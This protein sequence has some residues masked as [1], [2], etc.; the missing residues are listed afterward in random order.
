MSTILVVVLAVT[1]LWFTIATR[2]VQFRLIGDMMRLLVASDA[3]AMREK[4]RKHISSF[5]AFSVSIASRVGTGNLAGVATAIVIGGPGAIFWMWVMAIIGS[6]N[7][8]VESTLAQ[9]FKIKAKDSY[10]GGPAYYIKKGL[11][12]KFFAYVFAVS[13]IAC[14]GFANNMV[15]SNTISLAFA[16]AFGTNQ[17]VL[18]VIM[19]IVA[20][21]IFFG[22]IQRVAKVS[23]V[24]VPIMALAYVFVTLVVIVLQ[25][26]RIPHV[27]ALIV[28]NAFGIEQAVGGGVGTAILFGFKR[29]LFSNEAGEGSAPNAAATAS[30]SHPVNQGLIQALGV[31]TDTLIICT[32]TAFLIL[33][34][35]VFDNGHSGIELTQ[36]AMASVIGSAGY[37]FVAVAIFLFA[38]T[39]VIGNYYYGECN[40]YFMTRSKVA[41]TIYRL[42]VGAMVLAG[43]V[44]TLNLVWSCVDFFM[45]IM[46]TVNLVSILLLCKYALRCLHHYQEQKKMG[47]K[48]KY[49]S[50]VIPEIESETEAWK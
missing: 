30:T 18:G 25:Y 1:A 40:L 23:M 42:L 6:A 10:V 7:A 44:S 33:C 22:G 38:F 4:G 13:I 49:H 43:S 32:C 24:V 2:G 31:Y 37:T 39:S 15:Q 47:I 21:I 29:G 26:D 46:A 8:F 11:K 34:T 14:F 12:S 3:A 5:Q 41:L 45:A 48:P 19:A 9:L 36:D 35:G 17:A 16:S 20:M 50:S 27:L 28:N